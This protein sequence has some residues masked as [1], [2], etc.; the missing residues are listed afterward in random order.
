MRKYITFGFGVLVGIMY[1]NYRE[2]CRQCEE[3]VAFKKELEEFCT[4]CRIDPLHEVKS[5]HSYVVKT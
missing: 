4:R 1:K 2:K 3:A 5:S